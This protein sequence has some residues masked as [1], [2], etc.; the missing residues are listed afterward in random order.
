[1]NALETLPIPLDMLPA[2]RGLD[3]F[4]LS[5]P[6]DIDAMLRRL[7]HASTPL[8]LNAPDGSAVTVTLGAIDAGHALLSF[9]IEADTLRLDTLVDFDEVTVV[10]HLDNVKLQFDIHDLVL[11]HHDGKSCALNAALPREMFRFQR[12]EAFRVRPMVRTTPVARMRHPMIPE[13][14][15]ALRVL[16]VS[17][18]GCALFL[19][20]DVPRLDPGVLMNGVAIDLDADTRIACSLRLQHVSSLNPD[21]QGVRLGCEMVNPSNDG[22]RALQRYIDQTQK[23]RRLMVRD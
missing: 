23:R 9:S 4:R 8:I 12:R 14:R 19:P 13:M 16:D 6:A 1:M 11:V 15:L 2:D 7:V 20:D 18:G 3:D 22:R 21:A 17:I 5:A 10:G